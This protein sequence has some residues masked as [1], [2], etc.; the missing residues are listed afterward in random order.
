MY[1]RFQ[2]M[3]MPQDDVSISRERCRTEG[4]VEV[5]LFAT[6][7]QPCYCQCITLH[8]FRPSLLHFTSTSTIVIAPRRRIEIRRTLPDQGR[9]DT[10]FTST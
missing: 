7:P 6:S 8:T 3:W 2:P 1:E 10:A 5:V 4:A 9:Y